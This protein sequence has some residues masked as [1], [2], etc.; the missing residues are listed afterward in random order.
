[1]AHHISNEALLLAPGSRS[2]SGKL[3]HSFTSATSAICMR[4]GCDS[5][6]NF[7]AESGA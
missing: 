7:I 4:V 2:R 6:A 3:H 1:M 5:V